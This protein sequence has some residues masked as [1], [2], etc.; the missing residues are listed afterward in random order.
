MTF[1]A[2][3]AKTAAKES[4]A[5]P[6]EKEP[7]A[8]IAKPAE[9]SIYSARSAVSALNPSASSAPSADFR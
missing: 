6:A 7:N 9:K 1:N 5:E 4:N 3:I 2:E 8:E